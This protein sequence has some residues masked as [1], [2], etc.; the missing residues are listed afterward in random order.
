MFHHAIKYFDIAKYFATPFNN[1]H[2]ENEY[3]K[4]I[5]CDAMEYVVRFFL[6]HLNR[7]AHLPTCPLASLVPSFVGS[8]IS[9]KAKL[10]D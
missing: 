2:M 10:L 1:I 5:P 4:N 6:A 7:L 3:T 9:L 8:T